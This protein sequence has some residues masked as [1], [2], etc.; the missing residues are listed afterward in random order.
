MTVQMANPTQIFF[1]KKVNNFMKEVGIVDIWRE[2]NP[3]GRDY[4]HYS[5]AHNVYS[6]ID[7]FLMFINDMFRVKNCD[8]GLSALSDHNPIYLSLNLNVKIKS[9]LW[10]LNMNILNDKEIMNKLKF[11]I[12]SYLE[13]NDKDYG[14]L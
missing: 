7:L 5:G 10:R 8:I 11:E 13:Y 14:M 2:I 6:R 1:Y 3:T 4:T 12:E 9:T